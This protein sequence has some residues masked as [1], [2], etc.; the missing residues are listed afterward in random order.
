M[1]FINLI[2]LYISLFTEVLVLELGESDSVKFVDCGDSL[3]VET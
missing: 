1:G 3:A 2:F